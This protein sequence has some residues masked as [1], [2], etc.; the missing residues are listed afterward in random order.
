MTGLQWVVVIAVAAVVAAGYAVACWWWPFGR[1]PRCKG[2]GTKP[3][4]SGKY[5]RPCKKCKGSG[6]RIRTG[7]RIWNWLAGTAHKAV[8]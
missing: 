8:G 7:R 1:C 6:R 2:S 4:P 5:W 3:S